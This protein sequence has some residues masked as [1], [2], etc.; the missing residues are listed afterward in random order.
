MPALLTKAPFIRYDL[1]RGTVTMVE[2][3]KLLYKYV[4]LRKYEVAEIARS[5]VNDYVWD[6]SVTLTWDIM[7]EQMKIYI[8]RVI[9]TYN[10][11]L[12]TEFSPKLKIV[13]I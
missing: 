9:E 10:L 7:F 2:G 6:K 1:I 13:E 8:D 12:K 11:P 5:V 4:D 3:S